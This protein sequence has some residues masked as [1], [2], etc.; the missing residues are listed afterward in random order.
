MPPHRELTALAVIADGLGAE[1]RSV[2]ADDRSRI[3]PV[4]VSVLHPRPPEW[5]RQR[6]RNE[7]SVVLEIRYGNVAIVLPGDIGREAEGALANLPSAPV[8]VLKARITGAL[9]PPLPPS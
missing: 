1:W 5:E 9:R 7:D 6:V 4:Q 3:G 2:Q 8:V